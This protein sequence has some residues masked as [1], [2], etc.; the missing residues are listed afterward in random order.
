MCVSANGSNECA[1]IRLPGSGTHDTT[2]HKAIIATRPTC[3]NGA[4][5]ATYKSHPSLPDHAARASDDEEEAAPSMGLGRSKEARGR[6]VLAMPFL[7]S[8]LSGRGVAAFLPGVRA[9]SMPRLPPAPPVLRLDL[10]EAT[11]PR[12]L[13]T[14]IYMSGN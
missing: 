13:V 7:P 10:G 3:S 11:V 8:D 6:S 9:K 14:T 5:R 1:K 12:W 4:A 2:I